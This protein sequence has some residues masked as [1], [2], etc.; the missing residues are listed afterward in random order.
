M[1]LKLL[2]MKKYM[3]CSCAC[4]LVAVLSSFMSTVDETVAFP[5]G[6][7]QWDLI[8]THL[9]GPNNP[10][11]PKYSGF[12]HIYANDK[13]IQG[14]KTNVWAD[15][16]VLVFD[17]HESV[18]NKGDFSIGKRK[19]I[20]VM[21][22]DSKKYASTGGWGFEEFGEGD[23]SKALLTG[24]EKTKCANCHKARAGEDMVFTEYKE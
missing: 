11:S 2:H 10:A 12:N 22:R 16:A 4:F 8:K 1:K 5:D 6:Y 14:Y 24:E 18:E 20:D 17:V 7:R 23:K 21:V 9:K 19:F 15:G 3:L 13:A